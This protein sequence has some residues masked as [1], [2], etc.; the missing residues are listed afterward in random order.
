[1]GTRGVIARPDGEGFKGRYHHWDS[2]PE[3]LGKTL[4]ERRKDTFAGDTDAMLAF[5]IDQHSAGWSTINGADLSKSTGFQEVMN[6]GPC[7]TCGKS[8][9]AHLC[10]TSGRTTAK[11][12]KAAYPCGG[13]SY[14][15][16]LGHTFVGDPAIRAEAETHAQ[17]YCHGDRAEGA[18]D[19][20]HEN[21]A[22][23]GCEYAYVIRD[24]EMLV[25]SSYHEDGSKAIGMFGMGDAEAYWRLIGV[26]NLDG[27]EPEDWENLPTPWVPATAI[28]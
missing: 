15:L 7:V 5:L 10:Q 25:M 13:Q 21:A 18:R 17:C 12:R 8:Q 19:F 26:V 22:G 9:T 6:E 3:G 23:S 20:T 1:M 16:H 11:H 24:A 2:Y 27:P 14:A 28:R 4:F